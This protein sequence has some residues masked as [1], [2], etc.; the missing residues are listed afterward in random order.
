MTNQSQQPLTLVLSNGREVSVPVGKSVLKFT[1]N[2]QPR[3]CAIVRGPKGVAVYNAEGDIHING[4]PSSAHWLQPGDELRFGDSLTASVKQL[5]DASEALDSLLNENTQPVAPAIP[6]PAQPAPA[7]QAPTQTPV[8]Q[9]PVASEQGSLA[10]AA[11]GFSIAPQAATPKPLESYLPTP[12]EAAAPVADVQDTFTPA[13]EAITSAFQPQATSPTVAPEAPEVA[14]PDA[15]PAMDLVTPAVT[16]AAL[17]A[18]GM[19]ATG[20]LQGEPNEIS[21]SPV[22]T[23]EDPTAQPEISGFAADLLARIQADNSENET[24]GATTSETTHSPLAAD[25]PSLSSSAPEAASAASSSISSLIPELPETSAPAPLDPTE[26]TVEAEAPSQ[27]ETTTAES[28]ER[29][30][31]SSSVSALLERMK[32]EGKWD[33][34]ETE[35]ESNHTSASEPQAAAP[36]EAPA[37]APEEAPVAAEADDDVQNY[38]S[39]LLSRM[40]D[41]NA[42][43]QEVTA[44]AT[45]AASPKAKQNQ[46]T[47]EDAE[48]KKPVELLKP[49]EFVPKNRAKRLDSL[50]EMRALANTQTRTAIDRSQAKRKDAVNDTFTLMIAITSCIAAAAVFYANIFGDMSFI[51]GIT[52]MIAGAFFC[53][54]TYFSEHLESRKSEKK[55]TA[56]MKE[57]AQEASQ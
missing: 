29:Q 21:S 33:E 42:E 3:S 43:P 1:E 55:Q 9:T 40:R 5:G 48:E 25:G 50:Q 54:K 4:A 35:E 14:I 22:S 24:V 19:S 7:P 16:A 49:E 44:T 18:S 38:M 6:A 53:G 34:P 39:Q 47:Q 28:S 57:A 46:V 52:V 12:V 32:S 41:P 2:G 37:A 56:L 13:T 31:Q 20:A 17:A 36:E 11:K 8:A 27:V 45:A 10:S 15:S 51:I 23:T 30:M 26:P